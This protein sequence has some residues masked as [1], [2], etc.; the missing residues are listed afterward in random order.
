MRNTICALVLMLAVV[1][2]ASLHGEASLSEARDLYVSASYDDAL[3]MLSGLSN[4]SRSMEERQS[5]DLYRTLCLFALG[6]SADAERVIEGILMR[7][8]LYRAASDELSPRVQTAFQTA[9]KR[10]LPAMIQKQ[11]AEAKA[12]FDKQD[13]P[14]ASKGFADVLKSIGDPDIASVTGAPPLSDIRTLATSF[15]DLSVKLAAPPEAPKVEPR[16]LRRPVKSVYSAEDRD[17]APPMAMQQRV[18]KYPANVTRPL[19]GVLAFIVDESG[20][21]QGPMM[22]VGIDSA[23]DQMVISAA[24]KWQYQPAMLE[25]KP[26]KYIKRLNITVSVAPPQ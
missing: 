5:I 16:P 9:R 26:V 21:V 6:R 23:Y 3:A 18:P 1:F 11:Y 22:E 17:V 25:G 10:I 13:F 8:P 14:V 7:E 2:S 12:A 15:R 19:S 4:G 20:T 24:K